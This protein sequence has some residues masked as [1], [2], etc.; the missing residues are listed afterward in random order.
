FIGE[1]RADLVLSSL[2]TAKSRLSLNLWG[3][4]SRVSVL[5]CR[6]D[7]GGMWYVQRLT[8]GAVQLAVEGEILPSNYGNFDAR[9]GSKNTANSVRNGW[10]KC[11]DTGLMFQWGY[12][13]TE[14]GES[15][16]TVTFPAEFP[17][18]CFGG[19]ASPTY[20]K[21]HVGVSS[22]YFFNL[23]DGKRAI[24]T[25]DQSANSEG[26]KAFIFWWA[27]GI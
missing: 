17:R 19:V 12:T 24:I 8:N 3:S 23:N 26:V 14:L 7:E 10:W 15:S 16:E 20:D 4:S 11:G 1:Q 5:E 27:M 18:Q 6:D 21:N 2:G 13:E 9:Y 25:A 22:A